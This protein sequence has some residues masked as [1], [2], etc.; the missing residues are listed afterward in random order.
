MRLSG[1]VAV[2]L[3]LTGVTPAFGQGLITPKQ[4]RSA[5]QPAGTE[6]SPPDL[7]AALPVSSIH[8]KVAVD[9]QV[10]TV[11][12]EHLF[13]NETDHLLEGTYYFPV[14]EAATLIEFAVYEGDDRR[15]GRVKE[16][17]EAKDAYSAA[18][19]N[20]ENPALLEMTKRGWFQSH[21]YP[22]PPR[23]EKRIEIIYSELLTSK[24]GI[25]TFDYPLGQG[26]KRLKVPVDKVE[27]EIDLRSKMAIKNVFSPTHPLDINYEGDARV[28]GKINTM[29]GGDSENFQM[30][31][32]LSDDDVGMS[33]VTHRK[34]GE[35]GYFLL[36]LSPKV[37][38]DS[39]RISSKDVVFVVDVSGS[40][41]GAK[42]H[43]AKE[44]LRFGLTQTLSEGDRFNVV[45]FESR[46]S[47]LADQM[48]PVNRSTIERALSFVE[49]LD[50]SGGTNINDSLVAALGYFSKNSRPKNLVFI[51]D[52]RPTSS[53]TN[54]EQIVS[55]VSGSNTS[56]ARIFTF[57]VGPDLNSELLERIAREN[58]GADSRIAEQNLLG[59]TVS[60]FFAA[61]SRPVLADL[62]VDFGPVQTDKVHPTQLPDMYTRS[63]TRMFGRY[64]NTEDLR[65]VIVTLTGQMNEGQQQF[66][67][68]GLNFPLITSDSS[69]LPKM[70]ATERVSAL[71]AEIRLYGER[72]ELKQE[73]IDIAREFNLV[74]PYTSMYVASSV[75]D[76]A[77]KDSLKKES[78]EATSA[79]DNTLRVR[80]RGLNEVASRRSSASPGDPRMSTI[81]SLPIAGRTFKNTVPLAPGTIVDQNGAAISGA[82][83]TLKDQNTGATRTVVTDSSGSYS[84]AGVPPGNYRVEVTAPGFNKT[85]VQNV[86]VQPG[87]VTATG[88][89]LT[90]GA[91]T[92]MVNVTAVGPS[93][94]TSL[95]QLTTTHEWNKL[96]DLPSLDTVES[97]SRLSPGITARKSLD[98]ADQ[99]EAGREAE[100]RF[101]LS[102]SR[103]HSNY[104]SLNGHE[105]RDIDGRASVSVHNFDSI[106]TLQILT[107]RGAGDVSGMGSGSLNLIGRTGS[108]EFH[109]TAF[110]YHLNRKFGALS[111]LERRSGL[112]KAPRL[113]S[114][115]F[116]GTF[117]GPI[118]TDRLFFFGSVQAE[119]EESNLFIDSTSSLL[120][121]TP[122]GLA[123]LSQSFAA[124][125]AV[126][127]LIARGPFSRNPTSIQIGRTFSIPVAGVPIEFA[128]TSRI[129]PSLANGVEVGGRLDFNATA[130]D[131]LKAT[132][133]LDNRDSESAAGRLAS[134][135]AGDVELR[136]QLGGVKW[137]RTMSPQT[138]NEL[139]F[140]FNKSR[141][142]LD[143]LLDSTEPSL[144]G[145]SF[146]LRNLAYGT[147]PL[148]PTSHS[149]Y[150]FA[151]SDTLS[152]I[153]VRHNFKLGGQVSHRVT[154]HDHLPGQRGN[155][156]FPTF[157]DFVI[158][159]P[160]TLVVAAG[161][162]RSLF[163]ETLHHVFIDDAWRARD[164]LTL[165]FGLGYAN[166]SQP[167]NGFA[168]KLLQRESNPSS[169][170]FD[171]SLPIELRT[172]GKIDRDNNNFAPRFGF[173]YTPRFRLG[174][175]NLF[176]YDKTVVRGGVSISYD[177]I[178]Y[179]PLDDVASS[180]PNVFLAVFDRSTLPTG[181]G[182][183]NIP[184]SS[185]LKSLFSTNQNIFARTIIRKEYQ[186]PSSTQWHFAASRE[187][188]SQVS[189]E[190]AYVGSLGR[191]LLRAVDGLTTNPTRVY[192]STGRSVYH[193]LQARLD[194]R[195][196]DTFTGGI[197]YTFSKLIDDVPMHG[198]Q[199]SGGIGSSITLTVPGI[200]WFAQNPL[201]ASRT[202]RAVS[203]L[204][205]QHVFV[206]HF[207][208]RLPARRDQSGVVGR[209]LGGWQMSGI[210]DLS[211]GLPFTPFQQFGDSP[212]LF[213]S[214]FSDRLGS[215][216]PFSG[217]PEAAMDRVAFSNASN[218]VFGF[219]LNPD[220]SPFVSPSGFIL[221]DR[222]GFRAG[223]PQDAR[224]IYNDHLVERFAERRGLPVDAFG[225]TYAAGR[226]FG[227]VGRNSLIGPS[228]S[229]ID[230]AL[231]KTTKLSEKV[232]LQ[233][234]IEAY[235]LF[236][237][238]NRSKPN[239]ILENAGGFGFADL[240]EVDA[241]PRRLRFALKLIF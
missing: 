182:F 16:K 202:E 142:T 170:L 87:Q 200:Q 48:L 100:F 216:R 78:S 43:Q 204:N 1:I 59:A 209:L 27:I 141:M 154:T 63:Q 56:G 157:E 138:T 201:D 15:V 33:L 194:A 241:T 197:A 73:V 51:T 49:E 150:A 191:G 232:S 22:I 108:N 149:S 76:A 31:Y 71:L 116:G 120:T 198:G 234:R 4:A 180:S 195:L 70:W 166:A 188:D 38:F 185:E 189:F 74:T 196:S 7:P 147:S 105:N 129:A 230:F 219:F 85:E 179:R 237:K 228:F 13:R 66:Q 222:S 117:G 207:V 103:P 42:L 32:S 37:D 82:T 23:S 124:S 64:R 158:D 88:V 119:S 67:F 30:L 10:A 118:W 171:P 167:F 96:R 132:Y 177:H 55:N 40:M 126:R 25:Y 57:G 163:H 143:P 91:A 52:G 227:D 160:S 240:G 53:V 12:V 107:T 46:I 98:P 136:G 45:A 156:T 211:S 140:S 130:R 84:V 26:Y 94:N 104:Y 8:M 18:V 81:D 58:R 41:K 99:A 218:Q 133:W 229:N 235:N 214:I 21:I 47:R 5:D 223:T 208:W 95:S 148:L 69:F 14:P 61:V 35:D 139:G 175:L 68:T 145:V 72:P 115:L 106:D 36:M 151:I 65:N 2:A 206:G 152:H 236:N 181:Q 17:E 122:Q 131:T 24:D 183:P 165:T 153:V 3:F 213:A 172:L 28:T 192:E 83:V 155:F 193:S 164:N 225:P 54:P 89:E 168:E 205:R 169:S 92:E 137:N 159:R 29:G 11:R 203:D 121:P 109:G 144:P 101:W 20:N 123:A 199:L 238:P 239:S 86:A 161:D 34:E 60:S 19:N 128:Q 135:Y 210:V 215:T 176:G 97:F 50:A 93:I 77:E 174:G 221:A 62:H 187:L 39:K 111:P 162:P 102:G 178:A 226:Q 212:S 186:T 220:G 231:L 217:N 6:L 113:N 112:S 80:E 79:V 9:G 146:G 125:E 90:V 190:A 224:F 44:A 134:G 173:A 110:E 184:S 233:L 75:Q 127:D 114:D